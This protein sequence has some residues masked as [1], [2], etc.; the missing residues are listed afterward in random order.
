MDAGSYIK[1]KYVGVLKFELDGITYYFI[2]NEEYFNCFQPYGNIRNDIEKF[3][4]FD[5]AVLS[6]LP[7]INFRPDLFTAMT[8]R[9]DLFRFI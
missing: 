8:G 6:I 7:Q 3:C 9:R 1:N 2:D 4:F 5:K